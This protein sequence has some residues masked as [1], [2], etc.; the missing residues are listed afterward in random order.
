MSE[1]EVRSVISS[2]EALPDQCSQAWRE[3]RALDFPQ[4]WRTVK[5]VVVCGMGGSGLPTHLL[6]S[7]IPSKVPV[8]LV[9]DYNLPSWVGKDTLVFLSSY[10]GNTEEVLSCAKQA[11]D[12]KAKITGATTGG[13]L[14]SFF[15]EEDLPAL[16]FEPKHNPSGQPR[17]GLG[18]GIF[19]QLGIFEKL[20]IVKIENV[21]TSIDFLKENMQE[22]SETAQ[23]LTDRLFGNAVLIFAAQ[24][25]TGNAHIF[26]NQLNESSK[27]L[28][29][30]FALPEANHHLLEGLKNPGI[31]NVLGVFLNSANYSKK[32]EKRMFLTE[33]VLKQNSL[34]IYSYEVLAKDLLSQALEVLALSSFTS[35][36]LALKYNENPVAIPWVDWFKEKLEK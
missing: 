30:W 12:I 24:H 35:L 3:S 8:V 13:K 25:L 11:R 31:K 9:S 21:Q 6:T 22:L 5:N 10:S 16:V 34:T 27:N 32:I 23:K 36:R 17:L 20:E 2:I 19:G 14:G 4:S 1:K 29:F 7:V 28:A 33:E 26:A 15:Q 18:Y